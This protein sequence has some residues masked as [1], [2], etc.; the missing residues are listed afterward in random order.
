MAPPDPPSPITAETSGT[1]MRRQ[2][3]MLLA[4]ASAWPRSSAWTPGKAPAVSTS[5]TTGRLK[6]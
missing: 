2:V 1:R 5:E 3:S 4:M 6:R